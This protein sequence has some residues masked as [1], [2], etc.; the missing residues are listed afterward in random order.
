MDVLAWLEG[1]SSEGNPKTLT[2]LLHI[3]YDPQ[4]LNELNTPTYQLAKTGKIQYSH[5]Q[6]THDDRFWATALA[7]HSITEKRANKPIAMG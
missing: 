2:S 5:P 6:G 3:P 7:V 1:T 4:L